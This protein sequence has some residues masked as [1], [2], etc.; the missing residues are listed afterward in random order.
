MNKEEISKLRERITQSAQ[1]MSEPRET[2]KKAIGLMCTKHYSKQSPAPRT[3]INIIEY[4][5]EIYLNQL[6]A[7]NP[8]VKV[9]TPYRELKAQAYTLQL[10]LNHLLKEIRFR[11]T[12]EEA[13]T[14]AM[15]G[16][17]IVKVGIGE[18]A[19][20][21]EHGGQTF[22]LGQPFADSILLEDFIVDM[23]ASNWDSI[24]FAAHRYRVSRSKVKEA[25]IYRNRILDDIAAA[26]SADRTPENEEK[27]NAM[28]GAGKYYVDKEHEDDIELVDVWLPET[29]RVVVM[30]YD[31]ETEPLSDEPWEGPESGPFEILAFREVPGNVM[32]LPPAA[33]WI[34]MHELANRLYNKLGD[35]ADRQKTVGAVAPD[36]VKYGETVRDANDGDIVIKR[37]GTQLEQFR[38]GG[39]DQAVLAFA[40]G[41]R[42]HHSYQAGNLDAL[43]GLSAMS[44]TLGQD[45]LLTASAS[46]RIRRMQ[47][48]VYGFTERVVNKLA[49]FLYHD[50]FISIPLVKRVGSIEIPV[51]YT[52]EQVEGDFLEY[53]FSIK[54]H[55]LQNRT[56]EQTL[57]TMLGLFQQ[58]IVPLMPMIQQEG[59]QIDAQQ[60]IRTASDMAN[61]PELADIIRWQQRNGDERRPV[62]A[63]QAE[64][65]AMPQNTTRR[66]VRENVAQRTRQGQTQSMQAM[67]LGGKLQNNE[68]RN[69]FAG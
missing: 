48:R 54:P 15:F 50:P 23:E 68:A 8:Q 60:I 26:G 28:T 44:E 11:E 5:S 37:A 39:V 57:Q 29:R 43:G 31:G 38:M 64:S 53:N 2:M 16:I 40:I 4:T 59:G 1:R 19:S 13:V 47:D 46:Q 35:Q 62:G 65:P 66:Y 30:A 32:P 14:N 51:V 33:L 6:V 61:L 20:Q 45:Q 7:N 12:L 9:A 69:A 41:L 36:S 24:R 42:E 49:W 55:S 34:D 22:N 10:A 25:G 27:L 58:V 18:S 21:I 63:P 67:L 52:A 3:S 17:G 56:P